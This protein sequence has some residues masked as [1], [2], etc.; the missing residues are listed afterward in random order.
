MDTEADSEPKVWRKR[1]NTLG[2]GSSFFEEYRVEV[3]ED[4]V[5]WGEENYYGMG[6]YSELPFAEFRL[7]ERAHGWI[8][9]HFDEAIFQEILANIPR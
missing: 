5:V 2:D 3:R 1:E 4:T 9:D 8:R 7:S 6:G